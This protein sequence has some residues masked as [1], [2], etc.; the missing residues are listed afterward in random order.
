MTHNV[1]LSPLIDALQKV[2][3]H[4]ILAASDKADFGAKVDVE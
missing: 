1:T 3:S 4:L 2:H